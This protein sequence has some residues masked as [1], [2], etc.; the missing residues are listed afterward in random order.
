MKLLSS[1]RSR[2]GSPP[3]TDDAA[4]P[5]TSRRGSANPSRQGPDGLSARIHPSETPDTQHPRKS[6]AARIRNTAH[7]IAVCFGISPSRRAAAASRAP[8]QPGSEGTPVPREPPAPATVHQGEGLDRHAAPAAAL[9]LDSLRGRLPTISRGS[10][11]MSN[12]ATM[13]SPPWNLDTQ[14]ASPPRG[15]TLPGAGLEITTEA[16]PQR[17][18]IRL[19]LA[20]SA[21]LASGA[22]TSGPVER[23]TPRAP[24]RPLQWIS[25]NVPP[26]NKRPASVTPAPHEAN[27]ASPPR[28]AVAETIAEE[29]PPPLDQTR[30]SAARPVPSGLEE[31]QPPHAPET[32]LQVIIDNPPLQPP[33]QPPRRDAI[34]A[35]VR[36]L[37]R[38]A[39]L[40]QAA[41]AVADASITRAIGSTADTLVGSPVRGAR[42]VA[43]TVA[44]AAGNWWTKPRLSSADLQH[45]LTDEGVNLKD[46]K[47]QGAA[48]T[49][50]VKYGE[51]AATLL[52]TALP[53]LHQV[54]KMG[55]AGTAMTFGLGRSMGM[56]AADAMGR[57]MSDFPQAPGLW[58]GPE[59]PAATL[60]QDKA[61][62]LASTGLLQWGLGSFTGAVGNMAGQYLV[63]PLV[64]LVPRQFQEIDHRAVLPDETVKLMNH[65]QDGSGDDLR[66]QV[67]EAQRD[68]AR[69]G[70][71]SNVLLGELAFDTL[72]AARF[73]AQGGLPLGAAGQ[74]SLGTAVS[75]SAGMVI[76]AVMAMRQSVASQQI[77]DIAALRLAVAAHKAQPGSDAA[78]RLAAVPRHPV[79]LFFPRQI[80]PATHPQ[81]PGDIETGEPMRNADAAERGRLAGM[82]ATARQAVQAVASPVG[83]AWSQSLGSSRLI[84]PAA[85]GTG[86]TAA[87][88]WNTTVNVMASA[89]NRTTELAKATATT[90]LMSTLGDMAAGSTEGLARRGILAACNAIGI[91]AAVKPWFDALAIIPDGDK[92]IEDHRTEVANRRVST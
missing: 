75:A 73:A 24:Q 25:R 3:T 34:A 30:R 69:I 86:I 28:L 2:V 45:A 87:R 19:P 62:K 92:A 88:A 60:S 22:A 37:A 43:S 67:Q 77:P 76:G 32:S 52:D 13:E 38:Q 23:Q 42:Q 7:S 5:S 89:W 9:N 61:I 17:A 53:V 41:Q 82:L 64:N 56:A 31:P 18:E 27:L 40:P 59:L 51:S 49:H 70:S 47:A 66:K 46:G 74:V 20:R 4:S 29:S 10:S 78:A 65:L 26:A 36:H 83:Q 84:E 91:H 11:A 50:A 35:T 55:V 12:I 80:A 44:E 15:D 14:V 33:A 48:H 1:A 16:Q 90:E 54:M 63:A 81:P 58:A 57:V 79:P 72:T 68:L 21:P 6:R 85:P 39:H 8:T 71:A